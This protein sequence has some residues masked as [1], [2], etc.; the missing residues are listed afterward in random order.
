MNQLE[1]QISIQ[2]ANLRDY[3]LLQ[4]MARFYTYELSRYD[5]SSL[6]DWTSPADDSDEFNFKTYLED[7]T[8]STYL[9]KVN[10]EL[11]GFVLLNKK[12][13]ER[14]TDWNIGEFFIL[15]KFQS[16]GIGRFV[17]EKLWSLYPGK[18]EIAIAPENTAALAFW[19]KTILIFTCGHYHEGL[20]G[21]DQAQQNRRY[22]FKFDTQQFED[23]G[24]ENELLSIQFVD[25]LS[26]E[27]DE[28]L[29][30]GC[31]SYANA[32]E[33]DVNYKRFSILLSR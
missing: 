33:I 6:L 31:L 2:V 23:E 9:I 4:S 3:S 10:T 16:K 25:E 26:P 22:L 12:G 11:A 21:I 7:P 20:I 1:Q 5:N 29:N 13:L 14:A 27:L 19:R 28:Q 17:A 32:L 24:K 18:W 8:C 30:K 15:A